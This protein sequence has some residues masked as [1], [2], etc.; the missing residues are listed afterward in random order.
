MAVY[1]APF[2]TP[3]SR[4]PTWRFPNEL[5]IAG[6]P[7]DVYATM[8]RAHAAL[9]VSTYPKL[10]FAAEPGALVPPASRK[11]WRTSSTIAGSSSSA[12]AFISCRRITPRRSGDPSPR[13]SPR[14]K[15]ARARARLRASGL[16]GRVAPSPTG[17]GLGEG[18][19][20]A[21]PV[22]SLIRLNSPSKDGASFDGL[23]SH[24][25]LE[26]EGKERRRH[27]VN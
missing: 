8:E 17:E 20:A 3:E 2:P 19:H 13:S 5:P 18:S 14:S 10:L 22:A 1:R 12:T 11:S 23:L 21:G 24:L 16:G 6:E 15:A 26:G 9:A 4:R 25:L 27:R 7:A